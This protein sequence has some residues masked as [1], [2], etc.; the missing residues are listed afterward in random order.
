[1]VIMEG[2][3]TVRLRASFDSWTAVLE[4]PKTIHSTVYQY[5]SS[6]ESSVWCRVECTGC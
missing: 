5:L 6:V 2:S 1:V 4:T 3:L